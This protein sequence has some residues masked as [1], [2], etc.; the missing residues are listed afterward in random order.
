VLAQIT[1]RPSTTA[2]LIGRGDDRDVPVAL[3]ALGRARRAHAHRIAVV[4]VRADRGGGRR[5]RPKRQPDAT[6]LR[7]AQP[8]LGAARELGIRATSGEVVAWLTADAAPFLSDGWL[9]PALSILWIARRS[10]RS[11]SAPPTGKA[12]R[13]G[14]A[15]VRWLGAAVRCGRAPPGS[16][17]P[18][19]AGRSW[20]RGVR[21]SRASPAPPHR[22]WA[23]A[24]S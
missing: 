5:R 17:L 3:A 21:S 19:S 14:N 6:L 23:G 11:R 15:I 12:A 9:A 7:C 8:D 18:V 24:L 22:P 10:A 4:L 16:R 2:L 13:P 20:W 1:S